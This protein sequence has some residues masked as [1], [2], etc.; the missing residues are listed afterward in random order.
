MSFSRRKPVPVLQP[1]ANVIVAPIPSLALAQQSIALANGLVPKVKQEQQEP[2]PQQQPGSQIQNSINIPS[3]NIQLSFRAQQQQPLQRPA[4]PWSTKRLNLLPPNN[5]I[6]FGVAPPT[7]PS[8][9]PFPRY[10]HTLPATATANGDLYLFGGLVRESARNDVYIFSTQD[11][12]ASLFQTTGEIPSPRL[13]HACV[14]VGNTFIVWGGDINT[15]TSSEPSDRQDNRLYFLNLISQ[16]WFQL[17]VTRLAPVGRYGHTMIMVGTKFFVFG[18]QLNEM[19]FNDLWAFDLN[20]LRTRSTWDLWEPASTERPAPR[21]CHVCVTH[22]DQ[23]IIFGGTDG[24]YHYNDTWSFNLQTK[25][26]TEFTCMGFIPSA[27][28]GHAAAILGNVI[29]VFGGR[30]IDGQDLDDLAALNILNRRWYMFQNMGPSPSGRSG[31]AM[32]SIGTKIFVLGGESFSS[33]R[34]DDPNLIHILETKNI[35]YPPDGSLRPPARAPQADHNYSQNSLITDEGT[36]NDTTTQATSMVSQDKD[37]QPAVLSLKEP[38]DAAYSAYV[39]GRDSAE[40]M[41]LYSVA[42]SRTNST[43]YGHY[44][45][46]W[47]ISQE[48]L[49]DSE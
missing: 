45:T 26:W 40:G 28:E 33:S 16:D 22:R 14:L 15:G 47:A 12:S 7:L 4:F 49:Q 30:G 3:A 1:L 20:P 36:Q 35:R 21:T 6:N 24:N 32:A 5:I 46:R 25:R 37:T 2:Q 19:F 13:G 31:H 27:R 17:E 44:Y 10:G 39:S 42:S 11:N 8:P 38:F 18:G 29:Y 43:D 9:S 34:S 48:T 41:S 23:I